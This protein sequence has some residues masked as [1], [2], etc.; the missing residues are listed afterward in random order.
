[1]ISKELGENLYVSKSKNE[2]YQDAAGLAKISRMTSWKARDDVTLTTS[3]AILQT[4]KAT[5]SKN[6][7]A[8]GAYSS[9]HFLLSCG[10]PKKRNR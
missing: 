6:T 10:L 9:L 3:K 8:D 1:M 4:R 7:K 2:T 5:L